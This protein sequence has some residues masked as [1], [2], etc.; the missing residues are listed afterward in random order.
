MAMEADHGR[1][2]TEVEFACT[3]LIVR[4][5]ILPL[6]IITGAHLPAPD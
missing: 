2:V 6:I 3:L 4:M 5:K 1:A